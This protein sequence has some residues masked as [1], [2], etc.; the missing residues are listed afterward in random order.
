[1]DIKMTIKEK[2]IE[3]MEGH[4]QRGYDSGFLV[5]ELVSLLNL[6]Y[7]EVADVLKDNNEF[8]YDNK[9]ESY[10]GWKLSKYKII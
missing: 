10:I 3:Y 2:L 4:K 5:Q 9:C 1:M 7:V 6:P 8:Y